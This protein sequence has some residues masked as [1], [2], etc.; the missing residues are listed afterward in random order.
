MS[1]SRP[2]FLYFCIFKTERVFLH[3]SVDM[4]TDEFKK[5]CSGQRVCL[6][7]RQTRVRVPPVDHFTILS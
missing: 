3:R 5:G 6:L 4:H 1:R 2:L 7:L